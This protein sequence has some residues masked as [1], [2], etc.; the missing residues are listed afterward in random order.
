MALIA[1]KQFYCDTCGEII[2]GVEQGVIEWIETD[3]NG[4]RSFRIVHAPSAARPK[5]CRKHI[6][7]GT[8]EAKA[9]PL[10]LVTGGDAIAFWRSCMLDVRLW[11]ALDDARWNELER[12]LCRLALPGF[13]EASRHIN[14]ATIDGFF[15]NMDEYT[16]YRPAT[17]KDLV[18]S[19]DT[20]SGTA[21]GIASG[22][23]AKSVAAATRAAERA[24]IKPQETPAG[25]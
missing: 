2:A 21:V 16:R 9:L 7:E 3:S 10:T 8:H 20:A 13:E 4:P 6:S 1:L 14:R 5:T 12:L 24:A 18:R 15:D 23:D 22:G 11:D 25:E 17:L 19:Y